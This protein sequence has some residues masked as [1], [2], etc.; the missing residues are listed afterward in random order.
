M[1][2]SFRPHL[3]VVDYFIT[4]RAKRKQNKKSLR[5]DSLS[6]LVLLGRPALDIQICYFVWNKKNWEFSWIGDLLSPSSSDCQAHISLYLLFSRYGI[7]A[8]IFDAHGLFTRFVNV[9]ILITWI[10]T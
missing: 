2:L 9:Y 1:G 5:F 3:K 8:K 7:F 6:S 10:V 4:Y